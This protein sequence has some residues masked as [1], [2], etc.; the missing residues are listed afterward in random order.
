VNL[1]MK[2]S[3]ESALWQEPRSLM[4]CH[5][6]II[7]MVRSLIQVVGIILLAMNPNFQAFE[8]TKEMTQSS[9]QTIPFILLRRK[10]S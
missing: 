8:I 5:Q 2:K 7:K 10:E 1:N 3:G 4:P 9:Q 6:S